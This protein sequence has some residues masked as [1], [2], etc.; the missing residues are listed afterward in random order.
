VYTWRVNETVHTQYATYEGH[1]GSVYALAW[2]PDGT[3]LASASRDTS[4]QIWQPADGAHHYTYTGHQS[5]VLAL[6]WSPDST[7]LATADEDGQVHV[8]K[9]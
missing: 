6:A 4:V 3:R 7:Q 9:A 8:W 2:S 1:K 5:H